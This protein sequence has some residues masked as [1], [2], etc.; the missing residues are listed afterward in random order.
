M[1]KLTSAATN[2]IEKLQRLTIGVDLGDRSSHYALWMKRVGFWS[3]A[4]FPRAPSDE[5]GVRVDAA[6]LGRAGDRD[7]LAAGKPEAE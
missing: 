1:K 3:R 4:K 2:G 7:A 5:G 6:E